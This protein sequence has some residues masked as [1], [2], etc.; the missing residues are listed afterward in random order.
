MWLFYA[1]NSTCVLALQAS[2]YN[3]NVAEGVSIGFVGNTLDPAVALYHAVP[4]L[5]CPDQLVRAKEVNTML[6]NVTN[7]YLPIF[8][9]GGANGLVCGGLCMLKHSANLSDAIGCVAASTCPFCV[10]AHRINVIHY[11]GE[12]HGAQQ[13]RDVGQRHWPGRHCTLGQGMQLHIPHHGWRLF[14]PRHACRSACARPTANNLW[15]LL[16]FN[17]HVSDWRS[18]QVSK[19]I[20][21]INIIKAIADVAYSNSSQN[22]TCPDVEVCLCWWGVTR[23]PNIT[24]MLPVDA[25]PP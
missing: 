7:T 4:G 19:S 18:I 15:Q 13:Q 6:G 25:P 21:N 23:C 3:L 8:I 10:A 9:T 11:T 14:L 24:P 17:S 2:V 1:Q 5:W 16:L 22:A 12:H 20:N